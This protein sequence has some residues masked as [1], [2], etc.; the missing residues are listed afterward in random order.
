M[1]HSLAEVEWKAYPADTGQRIRHFYNSKN[2]LPLWA[3]KTK[4]NL[5]RRLFEVYGPE[6]ILSV[7]TTAQPYCWC[8]IQVSQA[9]YWQAGQTISDLQL[10]IAIMSEQN[11]LPGESS[12]VKM[13]LKKRLENARTRYEI[14]KTSMHAIIPQQPL[15]QEDLTAFIL[16]HGAGVLLKVQK[17]MGIDLSRNEQEAIIHFW[18]VAGYFLGLR[19]M[20]LPVNYQ[21]ALGLMDDIINHRAQASE[22]INDTC[23]NHIQ[24]I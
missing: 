6:M 9:G 18:N 3:N 24:F 5:A 4:I 2:Q 14:K 23:K 13:L 22:A 15:N 19:Q 17:E 21:E 12:A 20:L 1:G 10:F 11:P 16:A 7:L 8:C